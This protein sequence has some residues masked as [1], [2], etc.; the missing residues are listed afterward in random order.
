MDTGLGAGYSVNPM[1][2]V[3]GQ[4]FDKYRGLACGLL[5]CGAGIGLLTGILYF[6]YL[7]IEVFMLM[8]NF[9]A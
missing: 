5:A 8:G 3:V 4:Y 1:V 2:V 6:T 7:C 9:G